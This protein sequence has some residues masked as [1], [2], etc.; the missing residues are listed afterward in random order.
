MLKLTPCIPWRK[1]L[2]DREKSLRRRLIRLELDEL[3][4]RLSEAESAFN[5]ATDPL[6]V[7]AA[8]LGLASLR[9][10]QSYLLKKARLESG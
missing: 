2:E 5:E 6:L 7:E 4:I 8:I 1:S 9:A 10:R 3:S